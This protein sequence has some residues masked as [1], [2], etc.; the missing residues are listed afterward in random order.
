MLTTNLLASLDAFGTIILASITE[1]PA[2]VNAGMCAVESNRSVSVETAATAVSPPAARK[3]DPHIRT[4]PDIV[5][6]PS[7]NA[8]DP[9][10]VWTAVFGWRLHDVGGRP[11]V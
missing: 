11:D 10:L 6:P 1:C 4:P 2:A 5:Q 8:P 3:L 7:T 9:L